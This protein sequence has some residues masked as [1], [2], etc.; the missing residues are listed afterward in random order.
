VGG[1]AAQLHI[2]TIA[3]ETPRQR[4]LAFALLI[5]LIVIVVAAAASAVLLSLPHGLRSQP[6]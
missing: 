4:I 6:V 5:V 2:G 1:R 3:F